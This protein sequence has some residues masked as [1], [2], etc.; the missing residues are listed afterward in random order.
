MSGSIGAHA[1]VLTP[2]CIGHNACHHT[3]TTLP[4]LNAHYTIDA[5]DFECCSFPPGLSSHPGDCCDTFYGAT[6][7]WLMFLCLSPL[8]F[9]LCNYRCC[10]TLVKDQQIQQLVHPPSRLSFYLRS[11]CFGCCT[12]CALLGSRLCRISVD[13]LACRDKCRRRL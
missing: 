4:C 9:V 7:A 1:L 3:A 12:T 5:Y 10:K 11:S 2:C 13:L 6:A 8:S